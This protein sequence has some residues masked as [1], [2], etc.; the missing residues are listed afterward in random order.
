MRSGEVRQMALRRLSIA[1]AIAGAVLSGYLTW[2]HVTNTS[3][4]CTGVGGCD[5]V[6]QSVYAELAGVPVAFL[7]LLA[8]VSILICL[9]AESAEGLI[10]QV[11]PQVVL[12]LSMVGVLYSAYLT[13]L[14]VFVILAI[15]P[16]CV[17]SA[18]LMVVIFGIA[19]YRSMS[20]PLSDQ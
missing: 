6:Q 10:A 15:C 2:V 9:L 7:G 4:L 5:V 8:Y 3:V 17:L 11:A 1:L 14:E 18:I 19:V 13:Y 12:G 20:T 16:Y